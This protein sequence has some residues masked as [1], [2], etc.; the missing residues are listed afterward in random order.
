[1]QPFTRQ[2]SRRSLAIAA[3]AF[4]VIGGGCSR[5][6]DPG[7]VKYLD[8]YAKLVSQYGGE[9]FV[10][11]EF[12]NSTVTD[13]DLL[14]LKFPDA[15]SSV[16]LNNT[17]I[18]DRGVAELKRAKKLEK[19]DLIETQITNEVI[20][21]LQEMPS[22]SRARL[23]SVGFTQEGHMALGKLLSGRSR[24]DQ[25]PFALSLYRRLYVETQA[26]AE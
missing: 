11:V 5:N 12:S 21:E 16:S 19:L 22:L 1:M 17:A 10:H 8:D 25:H 24:N 7:Q 9:V 4:T 20:S 26:P 15:V 23:L 3:V 13:G 6:A 18:T 14:G 2:F